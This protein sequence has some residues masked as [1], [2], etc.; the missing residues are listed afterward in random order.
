[1]PCKHLKALYELCQANGV[2]LS[3]SDLIRLMCVECGVEEVCPSVL[4]D[5][6]QKRHAKGR[7]KAPAPSDEIDPE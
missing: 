4:T 7:G 6:Y 1:M 3:S 5:E 2:K